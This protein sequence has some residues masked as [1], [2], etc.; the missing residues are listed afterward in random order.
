MIFLIVDDDVNQLH[1]VRALL[2]ELKLLHECRYASDGQQALDFLRRTPPFEDAPRPDIV[3]LD[4]NMP[5]MTG[6]ELL[7]QLKADPALR[8]IPAIIFSGSRALNDVN[9]C[10]QEHANAFVHKPTDLDDTLKV[11]EE[12]D[13]FWSRVQTAS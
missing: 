10:Y 4:L 8:S 2:V 5:G 3:L 11:I 6:W 12:I 9:A 1:L 13:R 7:H